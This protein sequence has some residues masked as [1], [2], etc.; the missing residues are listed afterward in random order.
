MS[1]SQNFSG[2]LPR[3]VGTHDGTFHADEV[4]ACAL[5]TLFKLV[6]E[7]K[8]VRTRDSSK[9]GLCEYVCD[10][11]GIYDPNKKL[12]DH[13]QAEYKGTYSSAGM[14]LEY[15]LREKV[16]NKKEYSFFNESLVK[17]VDDFDNGRAP[18]LT[19]Y[20]FFSQ[21]IAN[22]APISYEASAE[23]GQIA[24]DA[25]FQFTYGHLRRLW[26]RYKYNQD[27]RDTVQNCMNCSKE[28]LVFDKA[29]PWQDSFF[30]LDGEKHSA[31]FVIMPSGTHWKLRGIP[32][33][34]E[35]RMSV[36]FPL[37]LEWAGLCDNDLKRVSGIQGAIFCHKGRFISVW[38]S[39]E[40]AFKALEKV[41][42]AQ[43]MS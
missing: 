41:L 43:K 19:G 27:C 40:D 9:L 37:P 39:K 17:G 42:K 33:D 3:S 12:F 29:I 35:H 18:G 4:T 6:D 22:F 11:G 25:A 7:G 14:I 24:F 30:E 15:L 21:I 8:I 2:A 23:E 10:V 20:S 28:C 32:P 26:D 5:L 13:H 38:E 34:S 16:I 1:A 31:K 36:R